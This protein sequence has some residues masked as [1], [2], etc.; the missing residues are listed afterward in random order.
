MTFHRDDFIP[1][2]ALDRG[3][4]RQLMRTSTELILLLTGDAVHLAEHFSSQAH[5]AGG[6]GC[7]Q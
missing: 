3:L 6:L 2:V 1:E 7:I 5:H 4:V